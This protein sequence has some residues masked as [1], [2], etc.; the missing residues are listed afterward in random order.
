MNVSRR[1]FLKATSIV[2]DSDCVDGNVISV[3]L[4]E[5]EFKEAELFLPYLDRP[6]K[7]LNRYFQKD[8]SCV[9]STEALLTALLLKQP[10]QKIGFR[11]TIVTTHLGDAIFSS[12]NHLA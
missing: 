6:A 7:I 4:S 9:F 3:N 5:S 10:F 8:D 12:G 1:Y 11:V 2:A